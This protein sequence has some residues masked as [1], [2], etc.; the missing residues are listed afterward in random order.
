MIQST[1][2]RATSVLGSNLSICF[3]LQARIA[4]EAVNYFKPRG[5]EGSFERRGF[6]DNTRLVPFHEN[7]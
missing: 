6:D 5:L 3:I 2:P 4:K 7:V 1:V